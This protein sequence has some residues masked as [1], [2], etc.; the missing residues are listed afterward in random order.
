[1]SISLLLIDLKTATYFIYQ[2]LQ[3]AW[4]QQCFGFGEGCEVNGIP[5]HILKQ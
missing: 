4:Q 1:M 2:Q 5:R 3:A